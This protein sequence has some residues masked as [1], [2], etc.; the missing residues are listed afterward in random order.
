MIPVIYYGYARVSKTEDATRNLETQLRILQEFGIREEHIFTDE[1]EASS[2]SV[3]PDAHAHTAG[4]LGGGT[5]GQGAGT[6]PAGHSPEPG[7]GQEHCEEVRLGGESA[8][9]ETQRPGASQGRG[10]GHL[11]NGH[12][13][14]QGDI[15]AFQ[16]EGRNRWTTFYPQFSM[17]DP[18]YQEYID[19]HF[20][21]VDENGRRYQADNFAHPALRPNL[22]Y[23]Y[24]GYQPPKNGWA[25]S[26][27]KMGQWDVEGRLHFPKNPNGRK[28]CG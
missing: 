26:K 28:V 16:K 18:Q 23:E 17:E 7:H 12:Q 14:S 19:K 6:F 25:I 3:A 22:I 10:S 13:L 15:F 20:R 27:E 9:Q 8:H 4:P 21:F 2:P 11:A 5:A 24:K 1:W